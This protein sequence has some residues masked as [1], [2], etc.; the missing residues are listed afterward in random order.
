MK[1]PT[2]NSD[3]EAGCDRLDLIEENTPIIPET[4]TIPNKDKKQTPKEE[5]NNGKGLARAPSVHEGIP[6]PPEM[7]EHRVGKGFSEGHHD[8]HENIATNYDNVPIVHARPVTEEDEFID[9]SR[10][11]GSSRIRILSGAVRRPRMWM[12]KIP[13]VIWL[14]A[15][16]LIAVI[17]V[18]I[19]AI[20]EIMQKRN[21]VT[22]SSPPTTSTKP[23]PVSVP[24]SSSITLPNFNPTA[25]LTSLKVLTPFPSFTSTTQV[26][27]FD[28]TTQVPTFN[29]R[30]QVPTFNP[31]TQVPTFSPTTQVPTF[32]PTTQVPTFNP[33]TQAPTFD[34][35]TQVPTFSLTM[36]GDFQTACSWIGQAP[37]FDL[38]TQAPTFSLTMA[39][40]FQ[41]ACSW[42]GQT[43]LTACQNVKSTDIGTGSIPTQVGLLT[44][45]TSL[46]LFNNA[47]TGSIPTELGMLTKL[48]WL[49][50][51]NN[52]L[53]GSL[54][55][56]LGMLIQLNSLSLYSNE[57]RGHIPTE[58]GM[59]QQL[60]FLHLFNNA[61]TGSIPTQLESLTQLVSLMIYDN[62]LTGTVPDSI[63]LFTRPLVDCQKLVCSCC[64]DGDGSVCS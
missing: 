55:T 34:L 57:L 9:D 12:R 53:T 22:P 25:S 23:T 19:P 39:G 51:H 47:L 54:P 32:S 30:T 26:P 31:T 59:L 62:E 50:L 20:V 42:I 52:A 18:G 17:V 15:M 4:A 58:L 40:D 38:T 64:W 11:E 36:A 43:D 56:Q 48:S 16:L 24:Q 46:D 41:T 49:F 33:T 44:Q 14:F 60:S 63:C 61:F 7:D 6:S 27:T 29:Q 1:E 21:T 10:A 37:T 13:R 45:L 35:T 8:E 3:E 5:I 2:N 28:L